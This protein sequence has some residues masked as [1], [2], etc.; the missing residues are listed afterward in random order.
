MR[1]KSLSANWISVSF[2]YHFSAEGSA[3]GYKSKEFWQE[4]NKSML[5]TAVNIFDF[6]L[7]IFKQMNE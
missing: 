2:E 1:Y 4:A 3:K 5:K 6:I 7:F